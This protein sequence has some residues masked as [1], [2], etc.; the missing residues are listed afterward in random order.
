[1]GTLYDREEKVVR[2]QYGIGMETTFTLKEI[3]QRFNLTRERVGQIKDKAL[4]RLRHP[5]RMQ[6]FER[7]KA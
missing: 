1:L 6:T 3:A 7:F 2:L 5:S 4:K